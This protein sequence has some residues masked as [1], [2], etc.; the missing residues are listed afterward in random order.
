M[1]KVS[2]TERLTVE[3]VA[4]ENICEEAQA[5][6]TTV[7]TTTRGLLGMQSIQERGRDEVRRPNH[8]RW[9]HED[10]LAY[11]TNRKSNQLCRHY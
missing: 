2:K 7:G 1:A 6:N 8:G 11:P 9:G 4:D 3:V 5:G 10:A